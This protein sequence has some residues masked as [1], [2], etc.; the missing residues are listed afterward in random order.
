MS[1]GAAL[2]IEP[3]DTPAC[4]SDGGLRQLPRDEL[5]TAFSLF[6]SGVVIAT[7][8]DAGGKPHGFTASSFSP[9]SLDP[10]MLL[11]CI[12]RAAQCH[13]AF[14]RARHFCIN[15]LGAEHRQ[16]AM[17]FATRGADKF[18]GG[19]FAAGA[20]GMPILADAIA[21]FVCRVAGRLPGG[22]HTILTGEVESGRFGLDGSAMLYVRRA[23]GSVGT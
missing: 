12:S 23:F 6:P 3:A 13:D 10:P 4:A 8:R 9:L 20:H 14:M 7:T 16:L 19:A 18:A 2:S 15:V 1:T 22:D 5:K 17:L 21:S 11:V